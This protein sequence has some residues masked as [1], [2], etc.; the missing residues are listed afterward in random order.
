MCFGTMTQ[1][2]SDAASVT[3]Y[4]I[5]YAINNV[6]SPQVSYKTFP[7]ILEQFFIESSPRSP[8]IRGSITVFVS[9]L[10]FAFGSS[11]A[12]LAIWDYPSA[13][14]RSGYRRSRFERLSFITC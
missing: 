5:L 8:P 10:R 3:F 2:T 14:L 4:H 12:N 7:H 11:I 6:R 13:T 9:R 1:L